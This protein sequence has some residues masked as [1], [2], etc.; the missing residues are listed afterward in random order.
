MMVL[1]LLSLHRLSAHCWHVRGIY[2]PLILMLST[3]HH[4]NWCSRCSGVVFSQFSRIRQQS[5]TGS[6]FLTNEQQEWAELSKMVFRLKPAEKS[7]IP[8]QKFR[9]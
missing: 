3:P 6:A 7:P 9:R 4:V 2:V 5:Q 8:A 1:Q